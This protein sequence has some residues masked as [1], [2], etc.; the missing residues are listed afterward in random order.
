VDLDVWKHKGVDYAISSVLLTTPEA[1][2]PVTVDCSG[3]G[4]F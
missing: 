4:K 1:I 2:C 3:W